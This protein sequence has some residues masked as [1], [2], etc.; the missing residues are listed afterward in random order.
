MYAPAPDPAP[1]GRV[2]AWLATLGGWR[3]DGLA[4]VM[5]ALAAA[6][7]SPI[8]AV[9]LLWP[10]F[11]AL[12]LLLRGCDRLAGAFALGFWFGFGHFVAGLYWLAWPL[13][14]DLARFGWMIPFAVL[15][16]SAMLAAFIGLATAATHASRFGGAG[17]L[18]ML[19]ASWAGAE[20]LRG[21]VLTGFP[22]NLVATAWV[23]IEPMAQ[24]AAL[25]GAYG[26]GLLT[27]LVAAAPALL[28]DRSLP[29]THSWAAAAA[30]IVL[31][32]AAWLWGTSR[33]ESGGEAVVPGVRLRLV[34]ANIPQSLK[35]AEGRREATFSLYLDLTRGAG[36]ER[37]THVVWP[38]TAIDYR[39]ETAYEVVRIAGAR[40]DRI[41][42]AVPRGGALITGAIRD[43]GNNAWFNSV[44][45][46]G[47]GGRVVATY[48]KHH[49]VPFGEYIPLRPV[50]RGLGIERIAHGMGDYNAGPGPAT[51][52]VPRA[53]AASPLVCYEAI[54]PAA[55]APPA[56]RGWRVE[57]GP[58]T[59]PG[60]LLNVTNDAWF[61]LTSGPY[62]H[63]AAARLRAIEEGLPLVRA[64]N[65]GITAV[66][67]A[68]GR[69]TSRLPIMERGVIDADLPPA[70]DPTLYA[71]LGDRAF[72]VLWLVVILAG[73]ALGGRAPE[74][75]A[76][77]ER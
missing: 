4:V 14:L 15:G 31:L 20:W 44:H 76:K 47:E 54:F 39:F 75:P 1:A 53:P 24:P 71:K 50:L 48:D 5:G 64:A 51:L 74:P 73:L 55:V 37:V 41:A 65:T 69:I 3:R 10:A 70:A 7:L 67:D 57:N 21:H 26:L 16:V 17:R 62:Q 49:L 35:W 60:W 42:A 33:I 36:Y 77:I 30:S 66:V 32:A 59:R 56:G 52:A 61:G 72:L 25:A 43:R 23:T 18:L 38:E 63:F 46:I 22:W 28:L 34:Q 12:L 13:T 8:H 2:A 6:S 27:V 58:A 29:R 9:P 45:V 40:L 19:A 68:F 11:I